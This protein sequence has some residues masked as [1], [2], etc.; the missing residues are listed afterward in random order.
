MGKASTMAWAS[1]DERGG[2]EGWKGEKVKKGGEGGGGIR[3][4]RRIGQAG[5]MLRGTFVETFRRR[6]VKKGKGGGSP[7]GRRAERE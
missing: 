1:L 6:S 7:V 2:I 5:A 3:R 4:Y